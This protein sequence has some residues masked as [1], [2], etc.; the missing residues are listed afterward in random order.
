MCRL[1][2]YIDNTGVIPNIWVFGKLLKATKIRVI[3]LHNCQYTK[4]DYLEL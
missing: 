3:L 1:D 4:I 2:V